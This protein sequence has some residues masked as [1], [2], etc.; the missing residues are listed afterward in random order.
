MTTSDGYVLKLNRITGPRQVKTG[1]QQQSSKSNK[2]QSSKKVIMLQHC[3]HCS[4]YEFLLNDPDEALGD[5]FSEL[6]YFSIP[7]G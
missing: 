5:F 7:S 4:S 2:S 3:L 6:L 1:K